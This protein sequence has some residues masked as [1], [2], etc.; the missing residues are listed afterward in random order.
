MT[1]LISNLMLGNKKLMQTGEKIE[2][3]II[4][5]RPNFLMKV[6]CCPARIPFNIYVQY[7]DPSG[8][9]YRTKTTEIWDDPE[10]LIKKLGLETLPVF[11][12]PNNFKKNYID[13][14]VLKP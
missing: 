4:A 7:Q 8:T 1:N 9:V 10:P 14:S 6:G 2:A 3:K 11:V 5:V 13:L 12:D